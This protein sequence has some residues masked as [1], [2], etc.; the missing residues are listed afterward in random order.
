[1]PRTYRRRTVESTIEARL[2]THGAVLVTGAKAIGK[3]TT[4]RTLAASE[5]RLDQDRAALTAARTDPR[6]VLD[7]A[8]PRLIDEYQLVPEM[9]D[10]VR[11][12]V[13]DRGEKGLFI[14]TG[15]A[16]PEEGSNSHTGVRRIA[17]VVMRTMT[18]Y[19]QGSSTGQ[20]SIK[21]LLGGTLPLGGPHEFTVS[22]AIA[23]VVAGGWPDNAD[24]TPED[25]FDANVAYLDIIV[26][27]DVQ[28][29]DGVKRDPDGLLRLLASYARNTA[30]DATL[31]TI[32][33]TGEANLP[34]STLH[35]Y[36]RVLK[37]LFLIE[38]QQSWQ[39]SL[40]SRVRLAATPKRHLA[41]PSLAAAALGATAERLLEPEIELAGF[42]FESLVIHDLRVYAEA[43]RASVRF[44]RD[45]KGLE[46]DAIIEATD[47]SWIA[48]EVKLGH[49]WVDAGARN[50]L[51]MRSKLS[52]QV[53]ARCGALVV[54][55]AD[56]PTYVR[57]DG[58]IVTSV[59]SLGP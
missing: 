42:L 37:R 49:S 18:L 8:C 24:L 59:A 56:S 5:V 25:A 39:P 22:D 16:T 38:D 2:R 45:N 1:M 14:L 31:R 52:G 53:A 19:E 36:L 3:S 48:V 28:R 54:V 13:D 57:P 35:D 58:V 10:A 40:R 4:A 20:V 15:S 7:G 17:P 27:A 21:D 55:V 12:R 43:N 41:D 11:G 30:S 34:E 47:G 26:N 32:G 44:Y 23:A 9:W 50:L 33:R 51:A 46:V 29:V 6:L